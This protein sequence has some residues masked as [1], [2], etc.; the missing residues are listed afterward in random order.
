MPPKPFPQL[1]TDQENDLKLNTEQ[2]ALTNGLVMYP[3]NF[4]LHQVNVAPITLF[5]TPIPKTSFEQAIK[6]QKLYN[7]LYINLITKRK[8]WLIDILQSL[9]EFDPDFS[10]KL[11]DVYQESITDGV[12]QPLSLGIFRSDYMVDSSEQQIKQIEFNT[13]SVSFGGLSTKIGQLQSF[14]NS[15]GFYDKKYNFR[16]YDEDEL[17]ISSSASDIAQGLADGNY[18][19]NGEVANKDTIILFVVQPNE[20]NCFDQR[21][22]EYALFQ[23]HGI[24]SFRV[25]LEDVDQMITKNNDKLYVKS[26]MDEISV[27]YYRSGYGPGD[28]DSNPTKTWNARLFLEKSQAI[29]CPS[30]LTQLS[31][32]KKIQQLLTNES[33][34]KQTLPNIDD[35]ELSSLLSTFVRILPFDDTEQGQEAAKL[36]FEK[37]ENFV[38]KPQREG[39]GNNI[40]KQDIPAFLNKISKKDWGA[41]ILME[42]INPETYRN[43]ILRNGQTYHENIVS[44]LGVFGTIVFDEQAGAIKSN[45]NAGWLLRSKFE[46]SDEGGVAAGFGC[47]DNVYLY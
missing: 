17:P 1:S 34:I 27:V 42:L 38:L 15:T 7:E 23:E 44:E 40:Y 29:K 36:A 26:T 46:T 9:A 4:D 13:V 3:P 30:I 31:G 10:G 28:Y 47:V 43:K 8:D 18:F 45:K 33:V 21:I 12:L 22:I 24:R 41:Y 32:S 20:R 11:F 6:V 37:P 25:T 16:Y 14:L 35:E 39:G 2:W 19:Y 5:P